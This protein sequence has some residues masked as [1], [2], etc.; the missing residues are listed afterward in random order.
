MFK[1]STLFIVVIILASAFSYANSL[2]GQFI[3]D[4]EDWILKNETVKDWHKWPQLFT[5]N[6]IH[7]AR[8]GSNF[9]RPVESITHGIDYF[10]WG[11]KLPGHHLPNV[12]FHILAAIVLFFLL[13]PVF[14]EKVSFLCALFFAIHPVQTEVVTYI[15]G[16]A[17]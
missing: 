17:D 12:I 16:R 1:Q 11:L 15:S 10:L 3:W 4:D 2:Q 14:F 6:T 8:K 13:K 5:Q 7:G 9:Y